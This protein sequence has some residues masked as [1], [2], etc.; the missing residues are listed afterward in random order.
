MKNNDNPLCPLGC[1]QCQ[2]LD[3]YQQ[4]WALYF[5]K[6]LTSYAAEGIT[7][8]GITVQNEPEYC[9]TSYEG[10]NFNPQT[11]GSFIKNYLGP[12]LSKDHPNVNILAYDHNKDHVVEWAQAIYSDPEVAQY[13]WGIAVHWYTGD[14][15]PNLNMTHA[16][17][18]DRPILASEATEVRETDP[19][20]PSWQKGE[21]YAHDIIGDMNNWV[22]G[23]IDWN[24]ILDMNGA[25]N[26]A[27][28]DECEGVV[29]CGSDGM[30]L[31]DT[32]NQIIYPQ[33]FYYYVG[34]LR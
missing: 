16:L 31:A 6:F 25:P 12:Q 7:I 17:F 29:K 30:L 27:G 11:E 33:V 2:L 20:N 34:H 28:P 4:A 13:V 10:M 9:P 8:W 21:H 19:A 26:H 1:S 3:E 32:D 15:F 24:L 22:V 5:S 23:F 18:P 14:D